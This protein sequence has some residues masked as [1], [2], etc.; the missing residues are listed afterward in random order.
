M[1]RPKSLSPEDMQYLELLAKE[2]PTQA[3]TFTEIINFINAIFVF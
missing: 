2:F 1:I 3:A